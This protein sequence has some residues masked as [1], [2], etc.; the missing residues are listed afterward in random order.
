MR[1]LDTRKTTPCLRLIERYAVRAGGGSNHRFGLFDCIL[2]KDNHIKAAGG[3]KEAIRRVN[4][5]YHGT[6]PIEAEVTNLRETREAV[7]NGADIIML[8]NMDVPSIKKALRV[9]RNRAFVEVSGGVT[10]SNVRS[11]AATGVDFISIGALTHS[12]TSVDISM[13]VTSYARKGRSRT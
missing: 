8:D 3:V 10:L 7:E 6:V 13:E 9:I 5:R 2:I 4:D 1:I 11:I 12:A